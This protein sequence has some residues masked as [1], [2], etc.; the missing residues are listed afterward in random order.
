LLEI[1]LTLLLK[2][3]AVHER[4][5]VLWINIRV[6]HCFPV[7]IRILENVPVK[8]FTSSSN[9]LSSGCVYQGIDCWNLPAQTWNVVWDSVEWRVHAHDVMQLEQ[10]CVCVCVYVGTCMRVHVPVCVSVRYKTCT[11][12]LLFKDAHRWMYW[13]Q[14]GKKIN[15]GICTALSLVP[16]LAHINC[17]EFRGELVSHVIASSADHCLMWTYSHWSL[18]VVAERCEKLTVINTSRLKDVWDPFITWH[19]CGPELCEPSCEVGRCHQCVWS[20]V[21]LSLMCIFWNVW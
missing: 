3:T 6:Q 10:M 9:T 4:L 13:Q 21:F 11:V 16:K 14:L 17:R 19:S 8:Y 7:S 18:S 12:E 5:S 1:F 20:D 15:M 2:H